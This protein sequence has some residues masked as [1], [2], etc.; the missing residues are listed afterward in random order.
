MFEILLHSAI[1][2][3]LKALPKAMVQRV[4]QCI[5]EL[6]T[7]ALQANRAEKLS[8]FSDVYRLKVHQ[9]YR[10][11]YRLDDSARR[12]TILMIGARENFYKKL[13]QR[14]RQG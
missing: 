1:P 6:R 7:G 12:I 2:K 5:E 3:D 4:R 14:L 11:A 8:G 13:R 9:S 10:M